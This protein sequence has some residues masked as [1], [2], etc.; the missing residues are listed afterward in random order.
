MCAAPVGRNIGAD[1]LD[2]VQQI[3]A[4]ADKR[5]DGVEQRA[6]DDAVARPHM[7]WPARCR[8]SDWR[9]CERLLRTAQSDIRFM[10]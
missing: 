3:R 5:A 9:N 7:H 1:A 2:A 4:H 6:K 8:R 10:R